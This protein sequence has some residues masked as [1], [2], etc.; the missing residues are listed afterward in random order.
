MVTAIKLG[1]VQKRE[2]FPLRIFF[3]KK[4][5]SLEIMNWRINTNCWWWCFCFV[6]GHS[7]VV[8]G[9]VSVN[10]DDLN[11]RLRFLQNCK[12]SEAWGCFVCG[13][14]VCSLEEGTLHLSPWDR[15]TT[16]TCSKVPVV[17][18]PLS[19]TALELQSHAQRSTCWDPKW[20]PHSCTASIVVH[21]PI[22]SPLRLD[23]RYAIRD[24]AWYLYF[25]RVL[26]NI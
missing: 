9:L 18:L 22:S 17:P 10:S 1:K 11:N 7:D 8:M 5:H 20:G 26:W 23:S 12:W 14:Y 21:W 24:Y 25:D 16:Q 19:S 4:N 3:Q 13:G 2:D 6:L 15:V